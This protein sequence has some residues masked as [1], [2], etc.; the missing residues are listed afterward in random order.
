MAADEELYGEEIDA[1]EEGYEEEAAGEDEAFEG[2]AMD[3]ADAQTQV[4]ML[5][6]V[7]RL[8]E[9][10]GCSQEDPEQTAQGLILS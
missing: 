9:P 1:G 5:E 10:A 4:R 7:H 2:D 3:D 6:G 8:P